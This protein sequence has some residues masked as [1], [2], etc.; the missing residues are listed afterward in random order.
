MMYLYL[1]YIKYL[2]YCFTNLIYFMIPSFDGTTVLAVRKGKDIVFGADGQVTLGHIAIKHKAKKI[3]TLHNNSV[4]AGFAGATSDAFTLFELFESKLEIYNGHLT[5]SA[6]QLAKEW[7]TDRMLK[8][9]EA[10][11]LVA[12]TKTTLMISGNGDVLEPENNIMA[13]GSGSAYAQSA[14]LALANN[15]KLKANDIVVKSLTIA[16]DM[17]IYTNNNFTIEKLSAK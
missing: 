14:A 1:N 5:K 7:R 13:I 2:I 4:L 3:R 12:D 11:L 17:C 8:P 10:L 16:S 6:I 9:L 15:T